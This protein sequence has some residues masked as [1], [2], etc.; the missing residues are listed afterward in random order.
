MT[1]RIEPWIPPARQMDPI[2]EFRW[3]AVASVRQSCL[4]GPDQITRIPGEW[5][6]KTKA[7]AES[8]A[9]RA[10]QDWI[11]QRMLATPESES[12]APD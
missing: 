10:A 6:G 11:A 8:R 7:Q 12:G 2:G 4:G 1:D 3:F 9:R 5:H